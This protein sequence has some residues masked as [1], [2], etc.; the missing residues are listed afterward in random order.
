MMSIFGVIAVVVLVVVLVL[1][2]PWLI[3]NGWLFSDGDRGSTARAALRVGSTFQPEMEH[4]IEA[5][6]QA[7]LPIEISR[8]EM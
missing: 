2:R 1:S 3:R 5:E 7:D 6:Q 8:D 4:V